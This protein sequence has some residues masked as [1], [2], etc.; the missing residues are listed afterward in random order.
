MQ[1]CI[2]DFFVQSRQND[3]QRMSFD[4]SFWK[5]MF[6]SCIVK[7][8]NIYDRDINTYKSS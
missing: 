2:S 3:S 1:V 7:E 5:R 6:H 4:D 8:S